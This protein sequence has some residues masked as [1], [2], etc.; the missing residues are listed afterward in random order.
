MLS[1]PYPASGELSHPASSLESEDAVTLVFKDGRPPEQ[2][3]NY[4]LTR[5]T[6]YVWNQHHRDI[7]LNQLDLAATE[8]K[9][10]C[11]RGFP[12]P[13]GNAVLISQTGQKHVASAGE[14][15]LQKGEMRRWIGNRASIFDARS[16]CRSRVSAL[17][18]SAQL[19]QS[20]LP[21]SGAGIRQ[22]LCRP[23]Q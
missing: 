1:N 22:S 2:I 20:C 21:L 7:P 17:Q 18:A 12:T 11:R 19:R 23:L 3:H 5:T 4:L 13:R 6:L 8:S 10:R 15:K 16:V 14:L 9:S